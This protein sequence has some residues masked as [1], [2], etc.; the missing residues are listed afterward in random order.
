VPNKR[1][2][3]AY[4]ISPFVICPVCNKKSVHCDDIN[5]P[6]CTGPCDSD[7]KEICSCYTLDILKE[8]ASKVEAIRIE[9]NVALREHN[10][11]LRTLSR[12]LTTNNPNEH[13]DALEKLKEALHAQN[14]GS[15]W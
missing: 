12:Y 7:S 15:R 13:H 8:F 10:R 3:P 2:Q 14:M 9:R 1:S 4:K 6:N 5:C 11:F